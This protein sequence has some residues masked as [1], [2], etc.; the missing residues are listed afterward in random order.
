MRVNDQLCMLNA[1]LFE[2]RH[3]TEF[4]LEVYWTLQG[5]EKCNIPAINQSFSPLHTDFPASVVL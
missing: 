1:S 5:R 4:I 2:D 3:M